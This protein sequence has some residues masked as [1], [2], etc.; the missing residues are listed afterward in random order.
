MAPT[1]KPGAIIIINHGRHFKVGDVV[2]AFMG[3][4]EVLKR[5]VDMHD[6]RVF[7]EG[8]NTKKSV[9]SRHHGWLNDRHIVGRVVWPKRK[10]KL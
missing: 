10:K 4:K 6:G 1:Y 9:D 2:V 8:D 5:I 3:G 7:L